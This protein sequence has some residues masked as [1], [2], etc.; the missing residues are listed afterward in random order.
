MTPYSSSE[1][2]RVVLL[3]RGQMPQTLRV[4]TTI[5]FWIPPP[6]S[7][8]PQKELKEEEG[9]PKNRNENC[10]FINSTKFNTRRTSR[11]FTNYNTLYYSDLKKGHS[12]LLQHHD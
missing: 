2:F 6:I 9:T 11:H 4:V 12:A 3:I 5:N 8:D 1:Q 10:V 7:G